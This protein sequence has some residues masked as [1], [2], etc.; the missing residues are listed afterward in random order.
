LISIKTLAA[1]R[2]PAIPAPYARLRAPAALVPTFV[3]AGL[4]S[5][6]ADLTAVEPF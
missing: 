3:G 4:S 5:V 2:D 1:I 6:Q